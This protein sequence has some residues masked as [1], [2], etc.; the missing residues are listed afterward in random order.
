M[1]T[2]RSA[3][4]SNL[5]SW[6]QLDPEPLVAAAELTSEEVMCAR[7]AGDAVHPI[8]YKIVEDFS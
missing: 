8:D 4:P 2:S 3:P 6:F 5:N 1:A 7:G